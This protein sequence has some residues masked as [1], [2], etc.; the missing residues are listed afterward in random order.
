MLSIVWCSK[1]SKESMRWK[2][3]YRRRGE[4]TR[5]SRNFFT[6]SRKRKRIAEESMSD[7]NQFFNFIR[8]TRTSSVK[9][10]LR[11][12]DNREGVKPEKL[13]QWRKHR[14]LSIISYRISNHLK[15][16]KREVKDITDAIWAQLSTCLAYPSRLV[17]LQLLVPQ[18]K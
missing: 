13:K 2:R 5:F 16:S 4:R 12:I 18:P 11:N 15:I 9:V 17:C 3:S 1:N 6:R 10:Y 14:E 7:P 8:A